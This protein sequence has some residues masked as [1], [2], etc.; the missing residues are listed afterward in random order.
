MASGKSRRERLVPRAFAGLWGAIE[1][2]GWAAQCC[3]LRYGAS[4]ADLAE[5]KPPSETSALSAVQFFLNELIKTH[6]SELEKVRVFSPGVAVT[7]AMIDTDAC[8]RR[9]LNVLRREGLLDDLQALS[10]LT[11]GQLLRL[12]GLG[13]KSVID[14]GLHAEASLQD[15][16]EQG[17]QLVIALPESPPISFVDDT[18]IQSLRSLAATHGSDQILG[19]D[20]RFSDLLPNSGESLASL[21]EALVSALG[22]RIKPASAP[23]SAM[24]MARASL[25]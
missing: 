14:F 24:A 7:A 23:S 12:S 5:A 25:G 17:A 2:P 13:V 10:A 16:P 4:L 6:S 9:V 19:S 20:P 22:L 11:Y 21:I 3:G 15:A 18:T 1:L 8:P